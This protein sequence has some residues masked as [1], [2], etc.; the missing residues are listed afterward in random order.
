MIKQIEKAI[1]KMI[2]DTTISP[3]TIK[4]SPRDL[5]MLR[6]KFGRF[7][8]LR[9]KKVK[10]LLGLKVIEDLDLKEGTA[11][12]YNDKFIIELKGFKK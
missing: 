9:K 3:N 2:E 10:T 6:I 4:I 5:D 7:S 12:V 11:I 1:R 8:F